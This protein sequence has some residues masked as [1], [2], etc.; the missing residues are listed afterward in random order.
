MKRNVFVK[1][2]S[3]ALLCASL[4]THTSPYEELFPKSLCDLISQEN[5]IK[6]IDLIGRS[7]PKRR[8][9][10]WNSLRN[11]NNPRVWPC[12]GETVAGYASFPPHWTPD[13]HIKAYTRLKESGASVITLWPWIPRNWGLAVV[14][15]GNGHRVSEANVYILTVNLW[16]NN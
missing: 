13:I 8:L 10:G 15:K 1:V 5:L 9:V 3:L 16:F 6:F 12:I 4:L 14:K 7:D 11:G 2:L